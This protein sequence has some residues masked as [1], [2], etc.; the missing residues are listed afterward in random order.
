MLAIW[1]YYRFIVLT[2][3][4]TT[5]VSGL[6]ARSFPYVSRSIKYNLINKLII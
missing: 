4:N 1:K 3:N 2:D 6:R 5:T